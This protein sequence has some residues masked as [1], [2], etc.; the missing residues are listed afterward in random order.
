MA[1]EAGD[2]SVGPRER[3]AR[4]H[5]E[6]GGPLVD[7]R[8]V[9][10][11]EEVLGVKD[12]LGFRLVSYVG[13]EHLGRVN[14]ATAGLE[15]QVPVHE[16]G[17]DRGRLA[18]NAAARGGIHQNDE[19]GRRGAAGVVAR[20]ALGAH[21]LD[22]RHRGWDLG[23][24]EAELAGVREGAGEAGCRGRFRGFGWEGGVPSLQPDT[25]RLRVVGGDWENAADHLRRCVV[26]GNVG[27]AAPKIVVLGA[28]LPA[29]RDVGEPGH[30]AVV[31]VSRSGR[32]P[33]SSDARQIEPLE[34]HLRCE[35]REKVLSGRDT[36]VPL[37]VGERFD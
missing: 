5:R 6:Q 30:G 27:E 10:L 16:L 4:D 29:R 35:E 18:E 31:R 36:G 26:A 24:W 12:T 23:D 11:V 2:E 9:I 15:E 3:L 14:V 28:G 34:V 25:D 13:R 1:G 17:I 22:A 32:D 20:G 8:S 21:S 19:K 33:R 7:V 37:F